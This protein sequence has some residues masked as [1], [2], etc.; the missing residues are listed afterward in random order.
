MTKWK[1][2]IS[3]GNLCDENDYTLQSELCNPSLCSI[4]TQNTLRYLLITTYTKHATVP[5]NYNSTDSLNGHTAKERLFVSNVQ[6]NS[7][8][9]IRM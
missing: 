1:T 5:F 4:R 9:H 2:C 3:F 8:L 6:L 7:Y